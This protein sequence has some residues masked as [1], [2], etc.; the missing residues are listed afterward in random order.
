M[1]WLLLAVGIALPRASAGLPSD[2][3]AWAGPRAERCP[4]PGVESPA[5]A[6]AGFGLGLDLLT[7]AEDG[8]E[9]AASRTL[10]TL[11]NPDG[12]EE[13][14]V[15]P[16]DPEL[17][18]RK[19]DKD[20]TIRGLGL[21]VPVGLPSFRLGPAVAI[22]PAAV[23]EASLVETEVEIVPLTEGG[24]R[25][26]LTGSGVRLGVGLDWVA[27]AC[28][29]CRL[30]WG[31]GYRYRILPELDLDPSVRAGGAGPEAL[32]E[33]VRL[34]AE[35]HRVSGR[36]GYAFRGGRLAPYVGVR[37]WVTDL[38][39]EDELLLR[40]RLLGQ[41]TRLD[42]RTDL[43]GEG[44]EAVLGLDFR[45][46]RRYAARLEAAVG[47]DSVSAL[48]KVVGFL[49]SAPDSPR[50]PDTE[51]AELLRD[52]PRI[53]FTPRRVEARG[54][55]RGG[56]PV[57]AEYVLPEDGTL[58][59]RIEAPCHPPLEYRLPG[60]AGER[61]SVR[62]DLPASLGDELVAGHLSLRAVSA[63]GEEIPF[64]FLGLGAGEGA[65]ASVAI[66]DI[67]LSTR[68]QRSALYT[69]RLANPFSR[70]TAEF[71]RW[72]ADRG[73]PAIPEPPFVEI[74][75]PD[76]L[77][78]QKLWEASWPKAMEGQAP[79]QDP[80]PEGLYVLQVRAW[81]GDRRDGDWVAAVSFDPVRLEPRREDGTEP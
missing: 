67:G 61:M 45:L 34:S 22:Y 57:V 51:V 81:R 41:E 4:P 32:R 63:E 6:G 35:G 29:R 9:T 23:L 25:T 75:E 50:E 27:T 59:M 24:S 54:V 26:S 16:G 31:G 60:P 71:Y 13:T 7:E 30:F 2:E 42:T 77:Y 70:A 28:R 68:D 3:G 5:A 36:L 8:L 65:V 43:E 80:V 40:D 19:F 14:F 33:E 74:R 11:R 55:L 53:T 49:G 66:Q 62:K 20:V 12:S 73:R 46:P 52:G 78:W 18:D 1:A 79:R 39:I 72:P 47:D 64:Q 15:R 44:A 76:Y 58:E 10:V 17:E 69:F 48:V 21:Q 38:E 37:Y 56:W